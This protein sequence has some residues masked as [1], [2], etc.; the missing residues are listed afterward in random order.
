VTAAVDAT[1][2]IDTHEHLIEERHALSVAPYEFAVWR[3]VSEAVVPG[4]VR[5]LQ[6]YAMSDLISAGLP[7]AAALR[8]AADDLDPREQ[9]ELLDPFLAACRS[10][11]FVRAAEASA[12]RLFGLPLRADTCAEIDAQMRALARPG[13]YRATLRDAAGI[14]RCH[15]NSLDADPFCESAMPDLL[16]Q[17]LSLVPLVLGCHPSLEER[18]G[19][20]VMTLDDYLAVIRWC[21]ERYAPRAIAVKCPWAY[22]RPLAVEPTADPP[23]R[24]F[25]RLRRGEASA[26]E[27]RAVEDFLFD[28]CIGLATAHGLPVKLHT[29]YLASNGLPA[30]RHLTTH[31][32]DL[33]DVILR[34]PHATFVLMHMAWPHQEQ[35]LALV[36]HFP[37]VV[38]DLCWAWSLAPLA[39]VEF[40][41]RF[42][43]CAP[44]TK[45]LCFGGDAVT[46]EAVVGHSVLARRGLAAAL[47]G[48]IDRAWLT[49]AEALD[50]V[51]VLMHGNAERLFPAPRTG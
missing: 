48:L 40:A 26:T 7:P 31:V 12:L 9:W 22:V 33:V 43:T 41:Q 47:N 46:P 2:W 24:A 6:G 28:H 32:A 11:G 20:D 21:F 30:L 23:D 17:D 13:Y 4:W 51:P 44:A 38:V 36:K 25:L 45:L 5:L 1:P 27:R 8:V 19:I 34:H 15:V 29:G 42:L 14:E 10:T 50:L 16:Q 49:E 3:G 18:T 35:L 37:N 39:A